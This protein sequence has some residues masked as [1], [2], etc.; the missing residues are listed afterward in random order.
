MGIQLDLDHPTLFH[1][2]DGENML[3]WI[4]GLP[5]QL[6]SAYR[7][8]LSLPLPENRI[9]RA[10]I[11]TGVGGSVMAGDLFASYAAGL[12]PL[13]IFVH[14]DYDLPAW[15]KGGQILVVGM[16]LS[17]N[18]EETLAALEAARRNGC[19][20]M[21]FTRG[22]QLLEL[23][24]K[25]TIPIWRVEFAGP[26]RASVGWFFGL[27]L[28]LFF[29]LGLIPDPARDLMAT[30][31]AMQA[32]QMQIGSEVPTRQNSAKR[33]AGQVVERWVSVFGSGSLAVVARRWKSQLGELAKTWAQFDVL[34]EADYNTVEG[35]ANPPDLVPKAY[36]I[37]LH[38][39]RDHPRNQ[40]RTQLTQR[41]LM[42]EGIPTDI[43]SA[44]GD[45]AM[46]QMWTALHY[47]DY[48]A[49][50]LAMIYGA[51]PNPVDRIQSI[52]ADLAA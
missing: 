34:P 8:G 29:R 10:I 4:D 42:L 18:A 47:G 44:R 5:A 43:I 28:A 52:Q 15:A 20:V 49:Y 27:L 14:R 7:A 23:A 25:N 31:E 24:E 46:E 9:Y 41:T 12:C 13:P 2:V 38:G 45:S 1:E 39:S 37:F 11:L 26:P 3:A 40:L 22:G 36:A 48:F 35:V 6:E 32:Q 33:L 50:Y 21:A 19:A 51:D 17:G 16:S 30:I